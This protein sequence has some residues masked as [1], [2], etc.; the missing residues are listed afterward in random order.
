LGGSRVRRGDRAASVITRRS[1]PPVGRSS[2]PEARRGLGAFGARLFYVPAAGLAVA[3]SI[4][5]ISCPVPDNQEDEMENFRVLSARL[6]PRQCRAARM[7]L[8]WRQEELA[9]AAGVPRVTV[10]RFEDGKSDPRVSTRDRIEAALVAAGVELVNEP[11]RMG[12][13]LQARWE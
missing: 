12:A 2:L 7:L 10:Q 6:H 11:G 13:V 4:Y 5:H 3:L 8:G 1:V 9:Q